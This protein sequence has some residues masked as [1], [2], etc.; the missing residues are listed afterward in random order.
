MNKKRILSSIITFL[1]VLMPIIGINQSAYAEQNYLNLKVRR[2]LN[3]QTANVLFGLQNLKLTN[4]ATA[5]YSALPTDPGVRF[6]LTTGIQT[7]VMPTAVGQNGK[8]FYVLDA[9]VA[10]SYTKTIDGLGSQTV[11]GNATWSITKTGGAILFRSNNANWEILWDDSSAVVGTAAGN[12][13]Y[14]GNNVFRTGTLA[15]ENGATFTGALT[16][17][18]GTLAGTWGGTPTIN[19]VWTFSN[20]PVF[21]GAAS[22]T[23]S[24]VFS[25]GTPAFQNGANLGTGTFSGNATLSGNLTLSGA[26][27]LSGINTF[28]NATNLVR[29]SLYVK[30]GAPTA[31][32]GAAT[33]TAAKIL[34]RIITITHTTGA[35]VDLTMDTG[36]NLDTALT[37]MAAHDSIDFTVI[38]PSAAVADTATIIA[39]DGVTIVGDPIVQSAHSTSTRLNSATFRLRKTGVATY[40]VYRVS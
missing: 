18:S 28:S 35:D 2:Q 30:Q 36:A 24:P 17:S 26:N 34:T 19:T 21:S 11:G 27:T 7:L 14:T 3:L 37:S 12:G 32:T 6:T 20:A 31:E 10:G 23:G 4:V 33:V 29:G 5:T 38:N 15:I 8:L 40:V 25:V 9:G 22:F 16:S 1:L 39:A 13:V